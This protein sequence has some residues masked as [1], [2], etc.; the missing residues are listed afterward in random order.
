[1][2]IKAVWDGFVY[3]FELITSRSD[4]SANYASVCVIWIV[5]QVGALVDEGIFLHPVYFIVFLFVTNKLARKPHKFINKD[6][7]YSAKLDKSHGH[8]PTVASVDYTR[9]KRRNN[10]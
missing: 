2:G 10:E 4:V 6:R 3:N 9:V 1:M 5:S 8:E 7:L